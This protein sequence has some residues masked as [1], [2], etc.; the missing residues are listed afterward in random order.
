MMS[1]SSPSSPVR[2]LPAAGWLAGRKSVLPGRGALLC[3]LGALIA[4]AVPLTSNDYVLHLAVSGGLMAL[5]AMPLT[6]L[7]GSAGLPSLGT[8][9]FLALGGFTAGILGTYWEI[10]LVPAMIAS[11]ALGV[12]VGGLVALLT[13]R[14]SGLYLAVGTL[15]LQ[16]LVRLAATDVDLKLTAA[17][18]FMLDNP[19]IAGIAV[20]SPL[21]WWSLTVVLL[22]LMIGLLT[23]LQR[24]AAGREWRLLREH[25]TAA[26]ALG[27]SIRRSRF[28]VFALSSSL[29]AASGAV[30]GYYIGSIQAAGYTIHLA[31][32]YL[33]VVA[34]GGAGRLGG[35]IA[36]S[37]VVVL[38]PALLMAALQWVGPG[39]ADSLA[40]AENLVLGLILVASLVRA[41]GGLPS[42]GARKAEAAAV[43]VA[44]TPPLA[45][46]LS[47]NG[48]GQV[49]D[50]W[51]TVRDVSIRYGP[52]P[53]LSKVSLSLAR[54]ESLAIAGSNGAGK[55]SLLQLV[56]G[57]GQSRLRRQ[58]GHLALDGVARDFGTDADAA[59]PRVSLVPERNK[60]FELLTV[61]DNLSIGR[62]GGEG[63]GFDADAVYA[64]F[65]RLKER[66]ATLAGNLSGGERQMLGIG[67]GLLSSP[68]L[69][70][71]DEP[72]LGLAVPVIEELCE[73]LAWL[74]REL[75]LTMLV[76]ESDS[77]WLP[78]LADRA[79]VI[80]RG[81]TVGYFDKLGETEVESIHRLMLGL[82]QSEGSM[83]AV[84]V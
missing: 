22:A 12:A 69:L 20:D 80:D 53:A 54:G 26:G 67:L 5:A 65:P 3:L 34:L 60:V 82:D 9:A 52:N 24:G 44:R 19:V 13:L 4:I 42:P 32:A 55:T 30:A 46:P 49:P 21:R 81:Q 68:R 41:R 1:A 74:R 45:A 14:V 18:G 15:A 70:L 10:G 43:V 61:E 27:V 51:L 35:A 78:R 7:S 50:A 62:R 75:G 58:S 66:R 56:A 6:V 63:V 31:I 37:Y 29:I 11:A 83:R 47:S 72:T 79:L 84:H 64:W 17:A 76:A 25:P 16:H 23:Y 57:A 71:L 2:A 40:G 36:A 8:A 48:H 73:R 33:T 39:A 59:D 38:L 77:H 28:G